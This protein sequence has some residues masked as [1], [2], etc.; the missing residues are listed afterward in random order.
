MPLAKASTAPPTEEIAICPGRHFLAGVPLTKTMLPLS[1][2]KLVPSLTTLVYPQSL[3]NEAL[4][5]SKSIERNG[6][7]ALFPPVAALTKMSN[8]PSS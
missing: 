6:P 8:S 4:Y 1:F 3:S 7:T 2:K 5:P